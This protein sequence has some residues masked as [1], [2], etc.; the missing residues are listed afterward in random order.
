MILVARAG[1][2]AFPSGRDSKCV[3]PVSDASRLRSRGRDHWPQ[4][5]FCL[6]AGGGLQPGQVIGA[7]D[8][9]GESPKGQPYTPQNVLATMY[10]C[11][12]IDPA[13]TLP[14]HTGRPMYLLD[15]RRMVEELD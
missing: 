15:D 12:G 2:V 11:V 3:P 9:R 13:T 8:A 5:G 4:S 1:W 10:H 7:T 14:D 6:I